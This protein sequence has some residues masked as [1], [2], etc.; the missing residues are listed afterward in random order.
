MQAV[1]SL[2]DHITHL[3]LLDLR[4][5]FLNDLEYMCYYDKGGKTVT[6]FRLQSTSQKHI[7]RVVSSEGSKAKIITFLRSLL[8]Q[9][10]HALVALDNVFYKRVVLTSESSLQA[11]RPPHQ[12]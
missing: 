8:T 6:A 3:L 12:L 7:S 4:K 2:Q 11:S 10:I 9:I 1:M 5:T